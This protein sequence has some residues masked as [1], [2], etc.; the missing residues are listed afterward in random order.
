MNCRANSSQCTLLGRG[1]YLAVS[2]VTRVRIMSPRAVSLSMPSSKASC[3]S[4]RQNSGSRILSALLDGV[5]EILDN[6]L[7]EV[8]DE[9]PGEGEGSLTLEYGGDME[10]EGNRVVGSPT[11]CISKLYLCYDQSNINVP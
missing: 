4:S 5:V 6:N 8:G 9:G 2:S 7:G 10:L 3:V 1:P 11:V